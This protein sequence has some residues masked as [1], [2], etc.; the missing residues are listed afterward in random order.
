MLGV[1]F[2]APG[3]RSWAAAEPVLGGRAP[4]RG[5][6]LEHDV[7]DLLP[8][9]ERR[10]AAPAT[11]LALAVAEQALAH[12]G[13]ARDAVASVFATVDGDTETCNH[14]CASLATPAPEISPIR[15]HNSVHNAASGYWSIASGCRAPSTTVCGRDDVFAVGLLEAAVQAVTERRTV[16]LVVYELP[17]PEPLYSLRPLDVGAGVALALAPGAQARGRARLALERAAPAAAP[18]ELVAPELEALR[19]ANPALRA[20]PLLGA[21]ARGD[22][23][24]LLLAT[25][26][27]GPLQVRVDARTGA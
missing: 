4:Y 5:A 17:A 13:A 25:E 19:R 10:R 7:P 6:P 23:A 24:S 12:A 15:F 1:G 3:L 21:I 8:P 26:S 27:G 11:R 18:T 20:L 2:V 9:A 16:L 14:I 22:A